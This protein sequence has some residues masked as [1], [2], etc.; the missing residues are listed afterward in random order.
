MEE[1]LLQDDLLTRVDVTPMGIKNQLGHVPKLPKDGVCTS[2][3]TVYTPKN[4]WKKMHTSGCGCI[5]CHMDSLCTA[6]VKIRRASKG[7][8]RRMKL[9]EFRPTCGLANDEDSSG[10]EKA[11]EDGDVGSDDDN[12][13]MIDLDNENPDEVGTHMDDGESME[14]FM[15]KV[16]DAV[17]LDESA[18]QKCKDVYEQY[19]KD[20]KRMNE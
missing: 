16:K 10:D 7:S 6:D 15:E 1:L 12:V 8:S 11:N 20:I 17:N 9:S 19:Q 18:M 4:A 2:L 13:G 14:S 3:V 5:L